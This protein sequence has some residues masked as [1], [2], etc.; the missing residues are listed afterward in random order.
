M[1]LLWL[2]VDTYIRSQPNIGNMSSLDFG[3]VDRPSGRHKGED[4]GIYA[5][6]LFFNNTSS[7][8]ALLKDWKNLCDNENGIHVGD[9]QILAKLYRKDKNINFGFINDF[10]KYSLAPVSEVRSKRR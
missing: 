3:G 1:P 5:H 8:L 7:S 9:H 4:F 10:T 2:D 6:C